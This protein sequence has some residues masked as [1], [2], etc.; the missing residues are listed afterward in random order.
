MRVIDKFFIGISIA[1][2]IGLILFIAN[3]FGLEGNTSMITQML[4]E[5]LLYIGITWIVSRS[6][7]KMIHNR[8]S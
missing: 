2:I 4:T 5:N 3:Y 1:F 6:V 7:I 8:K